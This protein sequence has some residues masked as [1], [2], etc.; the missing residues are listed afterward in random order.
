METAWG[1]G[2]VELGE[3]RGR[4]REWGEGVLEVGVDVDW[5]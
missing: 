2:E 1:G 4:E 3:D 5:R